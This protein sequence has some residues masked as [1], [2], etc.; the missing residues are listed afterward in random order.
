MSFMF[1]FRI[2]TCD[3]SLCYVISGIVECSMQVK[4]DNY[5]VW[6]SFYKIVCCLYIDVIIIENEKAK[7]SIHEGEVL[8]ACNQETV[9]SAEEKKTP[10]LYAVV[11]SQ[12]ELVQVVAMYT[13]YAKGWVGCVTW[14]NCTPNHTY[15]G[16]R[17]TFPKG[18]NNMDPV[19]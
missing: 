2:V 15:W 6:K 11:K 5:F 3:C 1:R 18:L 13:H 17:M 16:Y 8:F 10:P 19:R 4:V 7:E 9:P 12:F 14:R